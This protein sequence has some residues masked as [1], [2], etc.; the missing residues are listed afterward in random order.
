MSKSV[1]LHPRSRAART[2]SRRRSRWGAGAL[3]VTVAAGLTAAMPS[4]SAV[5]PGDE[6][7]V[8]MRAFQLGQSIS[9]LCTLKSGQ[10]PNV[11]QLEPVVDWAS[12]ADFGGL[13]DNFVVEVLANLSIEEPGTYEFRLVS[14]D[15][16]RL[17]IGDQVV[18]DH[19][20][21]HGDTAKDGS[22]TLGAGAHP[23]RIDYFE[24][25]GGERLTLSWRKP[26]EPGFTVVPTS[27]LSTEANV[28]R[29][30]AP[31]F[32]YCEGQSD[33]A[34][35]GLQ[36]DGLNPAYDLVD[37]RPAGFEPQ[38]TGLEWDGDDLLVLT[39][40]GNGN[41][42]GNVE[43]GELWRLEGVED[44]TS[45]ADVTRTRIAGELKEPQGIAVVDG[46][47]YVSEKTG[48]V[49]LTGEDPQ[50]VFQ[51]RDEIADY[52]FDG[53]FHEFG[54]GMLYRDGKFHVN[55]SVSINLGG[56]TTV[57][58]GSHD[59]GTHITIDRETGAIDVVAGGL[60][61]PH[62]MGWGADGEI[63]VTDN[64]G[65]WLPA[66]KLLEIKP[67]EFYNHYTTEPDG[68]PGRFD[69]QPVTK[70]VLWMPQN[71]IANSP[72]TPIVV[73]E[74]PYAGQMFIG[75]VTYGGLQR[76]DLEKVDGRH[77]GAL[78]RMT[79]GLEAGVSRVLAAPGGSLIVGG[80]GA[81]GNWGQTGK[82]RYGL[83]KL[84]LSGDVPF[85][86][87]SMDVVEGGF[88][89]TYTEPLSAQTLTDLASK[90]QL[91]QWRYRAT[92]QYGGPKLDEESL[93]VTSATASDD[94]RT[95]TLQV[96]GMKPD[97]VVH[98][99]SPRPFDSA[100]GETLWS[101]EAWYTL[102]SYPGYVA[103][104]PEP[105]PDGI[106]ELEDGDLSGTAGVA[107]EHAGYTG[108][109]FVDGIQTVGSGTAVEVV[110][111]RAGAY[112]LQIRYANG[113]NPQPNQAKKMSLYV[114]EERQQIT[115]PPFADWKT[116]G[117][118]TTRVTLPA[119]ATRV[120]LA[121]EQG[122]DGNVNLDHLKVVDP[123]G[124]RVEAEDG[125][126]T[127]DGNRVQTEHAGYS[128][129]GYVG[130]FEND[131][132]AVTFDVIATRAG[133]HAIKLGY[134][135]GPNP[136]P[137]QTKAM[138]LYV[139]DV[140][141][142]KLSL[143]PT[144][145][146]KDWG[147][148]E[149]QIE[150]EAGLN[151]VR[152][153]RDAGDNGN[154]NLDYLDLGAR[155]ACAPGETPGADD[156]FDGDTLDTCRWSTVLNKTSSGV[157]VT[158]GHLR[159]NAQSGDLSSGAVDAKNVILQDAPAEGS[160]AATTQFTMTGTDDYLQG[161]LV[162]WTDARNYAKLVA[163]E[164]PEGTWVLELGRRINGE[165]VYANADLPGGTAPED[166][167][168]QM[169]STG[170]AVQGRW[171][172]DQGATW[173]SMGSGYPSTGLVDPKI[174]VAAY[175]GTGSQV[176]E[177]DWFRVSGD[178]VV[179]PDT[180]APTT[181]DPGYRMLFD[182]TAESLQDWDM[183][184]PGL[185]TR[186]ADCSLKTNGGMGLLW[187]SEPLEGDYSLQLDWKLTKDDNGGVF[188]G[189]P[190]PGNDP[191][192]AV[193]NGYE[194]QI[195]ASDLPDRTTGAVYTFQGANAQRDSALKGLNEWNHYEIRVEG[196]RIRVYLNDVLVNDF[197]SPEAEDNR[198]TWP[199]YFGLQNHG[200]GENVFYRD[201]QVKELADPENVPSTVTV[202]A[203]AQVET[204]AKARVEV[205][206]TS[207][208]PEAPTGEV[209]LS[210]NGSDLPPAQLKEG[211][212]TIEVGPFQAAGTVE[213]VA[214]YAGDLAVDAGRGSTRL[215]VV[216]PT[217]P[218]V[219]PVVPP[220][221]DPVVAVKKGGKVDATRDRRR[222]RMVLSCGSAPCEGKVVLRT[223][224]ATGT[225][226]GAGAFDL[227]A[228][229][230]GTVTLRLTQRARALLG[231][232]ATVKAV[233]VVRHE[234]GSTQRVKVRLTR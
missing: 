232:K 163:M 201:V 57:P 99:R 17:T 58:Q 13:E 5:P 182:G 147:S 31:G 199:S 69:D 67:G 8:T 204:G 68:S 212:A 225:R 184:G 139:D 179:E 158:E 84:D 142:K 70:P 170:S 175:N 97:R 206:V 144:G 117:T 120:E 60:R 76:A 18:V 63:F 200:G 186:E 75:D 168:L 20:G 72:S 104:D 223:R 137:D 27:A 111:P 77:Q 161:G 52:P 26:G 98:L 133:Y 105:A 203:P 165:M 23:L 116:W 53:N 188:V 233:L 145:M 59:R 79:Q 155:S 14:D 140:F 100:S 150:L 211:K 38:V 65:G 33:S 123:T 115:L 131:G 167:Q 130:G 231:K 217:P 47:I 187:H 37:L 24:A 74:G 125:T 214:S 103:P 25:G 234:D 208:A 62:G 183:A 91:E 219:P 101:T 89:I 146:W 202:T 21:L 109:G 160:W 86:M 11:D 95:V 71:E 2:G 227:D 22:I 78:F 221:V 171:S 220:S 102:N 149:D 36:L 107:T 132:T 215:E 112:D 43:L 138:S 126:I 56:A 19:D 194:I 85:D 213:L 135:N 190:D 61:T 181:A 15:G 39:W 169:V 156:E 148:I 152:I 114:G 159:I 143:P 94:G 207:A 172:T 162:A 30:T 127:G 121:Y 224:G 35:D 16:S 136:Q 176:G 118:L 180:C 55:L 222:A 228:R 229:E 4:A 110:A 218:V 34:G 113:P 106:Y 80:L 3:A 196:K 54:F 73:E 108:S 28:T 197:T 12:P 177:F 205:A 32:K 195:D 81:G 174:G 92:A 128:G 93:I 6:A 29:V 185:F 1:V 216:R 193:D 230:K 209:V 87:A 44:A 9:E 49:R 157:A 189:F 129:T 226:L 166:L 210:V 66:S 198:L 64:Q 96:E 192:V 83:Q 7:G 10:T 119:G 124:G 134:A 141:V 122:D 164:K 45:P 151:V 178:P 46:E 154:V 88:E 40:G 51:T 42:Q 90:Y 191:W 82:L 48:L 41:D 50:G 153:Q 173:T